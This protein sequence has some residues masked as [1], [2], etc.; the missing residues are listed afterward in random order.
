MRPQPAL[1]RTRW[2]VK[3]KKTCRACS[4]W[5]PAPSCAVMT[6]GY[7]NE[8][9]RRDQISRTKRHLRVLSLLSEKAR[10]EEDVAAELIHAIP[11]PLLPLLFLPLAHLLPAAP[12]SLL[13]QPHPLPL[14]PER[15]GSRR[16]QQR[17]LL[18]RRPPHGALLLRLQH[19]RR[20]TAGVPGG[21]PPRPRPRP[22]A[23][24]SGAAAGAAHGAAGPPG[25]AAVPG[26][27]PR[28][29]PH[30]LR[31]LHRRQEHGR[32]RQ[33]RGDGGRR[34]GAGCAAGAGRGGGRAG[35]AVQAHGGRAARERAVPAQLRAV[36]ARGEGRR[37]E[38]GGVLLARHAGGPRR[39]RDHVAVRQAGLGG[40]PRPGE[41]PRLLPQVRAGRPTE[42]PCPR[43]V[44]QLPVGAG[45]RRR[46]RG[47]RAGHGWGWSARSAR[48]NYTAG[49]AGEGTGFGGRL[50]PSG[51]AW[52]VQAM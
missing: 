2:P 9:T 46:P 43:R 44:R 6:C 42:Q 21:A 11:A 20:R 45:R 12:A 33:G 36:P 29:R 8:D 47:R 1:E 32:G 41:V 34:G 24:R 28:D 14:H 13:R 16:H 39:R 15:R 50:I 7:I 35:R 5:P 10:R 3:E 37:D 22:A 25:G 17:T 18:R 49:W 30:R 26:E 4:H 27:G 48:C 31:L 52:R 23:R 19:R 38:G 51:A 40:A